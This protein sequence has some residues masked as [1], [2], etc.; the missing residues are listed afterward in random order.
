VVIGDVVQLRQQM[1]W[2]ERLPLFG[3]RVLVTRDASQSASL[4]E[5]LRAVGGEAVLAP[6]IQLAPPESWDEVD[7]ALAHLDG[8]DA[9]LLTSANAARFLAARAAA[10]AVPLAQPGLRVFCVG[11]ETAKA[12]REV[13][14][15]VHH[16][17]VEGS[18]SRAL[19]EEVRRQ[20]PPQGRRFLL[21][22]SARARPELPEGLATDGATVAAV[23]V[24]RTL[25]PRTSAETLRTLLLEP[26]LDALTFTSPSTVLHFAERL[27]TD[28]RAAAGRCIVAAIGS[29]TAEALRRAGLAADVTAE[30]AGVAGLV[31][32]LVDRLSPMDAGGRR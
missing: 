8:F 11:P 9:L 32:A 19:L 26:G 6:M 29:V 28:S 16:V 17:P 13:G 15:P 4:V 31:A 1:A 7:E 24:Y 5:A 14:I 18:D 21:P 25:P 23:T 22:R 3:K 12:A 10:R 2:F 30:R 20:L 27:D